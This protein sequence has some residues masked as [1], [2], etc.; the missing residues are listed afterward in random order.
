VTNQA[1]SPLT[2]IVDEFCSGDALARRLLH[3]ESQRVRLRQGEILFVQGDP[4]DSMYLLLQGRLSVR[5]RHADGSEMVL[6]ELGSG[7]LLEGQP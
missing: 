7:A 4:G 3:G 2:H 1:Q 5:L 6:A